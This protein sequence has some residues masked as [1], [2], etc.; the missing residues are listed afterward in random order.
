MV[1]LEIRNRIIDELLIE[2]NLKSIL[3]NYT[4]HRLTGFAFSSGT[5]WFEIFRGCPQGSCL[6]P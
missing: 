4:S 5:E 2:D 1:S 3:K 6:D